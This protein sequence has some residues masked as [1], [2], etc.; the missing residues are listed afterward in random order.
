MA[1]VVHIPGRDQGRRIT[2]NEGTFVRQA[3]LGPAVGLADRV[4]SL[5]G[6]DSADGGDTDPAP[7]GVGV[8]HHALRPVHKHQARAAFGPDQPPITRLDGRKLG[9][10]RV[11]EV[12]IGG[13]FHQEPPDLLH[14]R[15]IGGT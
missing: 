5:M 7:V 9:D 15:D 4:P 13:Q 1:V 2:V 10:Q 6:L 14:V 3:Q 11:E 8:A 12:L